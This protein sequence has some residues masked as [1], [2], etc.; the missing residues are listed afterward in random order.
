LAIEK[1][2]RDGVVYAIVAHPED[3]KAEKSTFFTPGDETMQV[4]VIAN[5]AGYVEKAHYHAE[6]K[7]LV[8]GVHQML[9]VTKGKAALD[10]F[11]SSKKIFKSVELNVGDLMLIMDGIHR[12]RVIA[13]FSAV[14]AKQGPYISPEKDKVN[15]E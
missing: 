3:M 6:N 15:V 4:G 5:K 9:Y 10:F 2:E 11:D 7:R 8:A 14:T 12:L 1:I 13:D